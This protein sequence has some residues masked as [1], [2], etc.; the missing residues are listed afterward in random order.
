MLVYL[1]PE[2]CDKLHAR[3]ISQDLFMDQQKIFHSS[4]AK[5]RQ[6]KRPKSYDIHNETKKQTLNAKLCYQ[7]GCAHFK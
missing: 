6:N 3:I 5:W 7:M 1:G 4:C 2:L